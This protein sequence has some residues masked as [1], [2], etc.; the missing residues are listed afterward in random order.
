MA[1]GSTSEQEIINSLNL[2]VNSKGYIE[3]N[4]CYQTSDEKVYAGGDIAGT[5]AT[6]AW[7]ARSGREAANN[8]IEGLKWDK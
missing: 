2:K 5:K 1:I 4:E 8:I 6:V 7:A 3:V